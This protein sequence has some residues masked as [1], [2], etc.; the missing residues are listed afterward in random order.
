MAMN[1]SPTTLEQSGL[2]DIETEY[3][4]DQ[5]KLDQLELDQL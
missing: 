4:L 5:L 1:E 2:D 3:D